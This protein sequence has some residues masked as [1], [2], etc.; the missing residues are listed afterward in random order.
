VVKLEKIA[1]C[2]IDNSC[3]LVQWI[4][5]SDEEAFFNRY[6]EKIAPG[7]MIDEYLD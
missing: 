6:I 5:L 3:L 7:G 1:I 2:P 4:A